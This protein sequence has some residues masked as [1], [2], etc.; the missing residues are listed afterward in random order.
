MPKHE[1]KLLISVLCNLFHPYLYIFL[2]ILK[3]LI[4]GKDRHVMIRSD[5][6]NEKID[7]R[8]LDTVVPALIEKLCGYFISSCVVM[9]KSS[10]M[11]SLSRKVVNFF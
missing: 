5:G 6:T 7:I 4:Q 2:I 1:R 11:E 8:S 3:I 9:G 10:K